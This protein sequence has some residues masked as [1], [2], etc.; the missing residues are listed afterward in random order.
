VGRGLLTGVVVSGLAG[1]AGW[2]LV[3]DGKAQWT[4]VAGAVAAVVGAFSPSVVDRVR[5][6]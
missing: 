3:S 5:R 6:R 4:V 1:V 2:S